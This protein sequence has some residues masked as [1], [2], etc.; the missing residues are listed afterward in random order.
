MENCGTV[1]LVIQKSP[2][3]IDTPVS[4]SYETIEGEAKAGEDYVHV[5]KRIHIP[6]GVAEQVVRRDNCSPD[7]PSHA[8]PPSFCLELVRD[9]VLIDP[10]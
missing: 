10:T 4:V 1:N 7:F 2:D 6:S 9:P 8:P 5:R 3:L